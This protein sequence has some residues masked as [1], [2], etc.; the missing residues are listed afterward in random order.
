MDACLGRRRTGSAPERR[1]GGPTGCT[2]AAN[3]E[4]DQG[5]LVRARVDRVRRAYLKERARDVVPGVAVSS[6]IRG[7]AREWLDG[8]LR[9]SSRWPPEAYDRVATAPR[10]A[11]ASLSPL[12]RARFLVALVGPSAASWPLDEDGGGEGELAQRA[13]AL[14]SR[15]ESGGVDAGRPRLAGRFVRSWAGCSPGRRHTHGGRWGS[16]WERRAGGVSGPRARPGRSESACRGGR[17]GRRRARTR[18]AHAR[19]SAGFRVGARRRDGAG[20]RCPP[21]AVRRRPRRPPRRA[22]SPLG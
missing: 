19:P 14:A 20:G 6:D 3:L 10:A 13:V 15:L 1:V 18:A 7:V 16:A 2:L 17:G 12:R 9:W 4:P 21:R 22:G 11:L 8:V 5:E